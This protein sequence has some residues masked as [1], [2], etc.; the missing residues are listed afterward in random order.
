M[1]SRPQG[2]RAPGAW[3]EAR[4]P[5]SQEKPLQG[6]NPKGPRPRGDRPE[7]AR[8]GWP[9]LVT[10][11]RLSVP[12]VS[13]RFP[14]QVPMSCSQRGRRLGALWLLSLGTLCLSDLIRQDGHLGTVGSLPPRGTL[15]PAPSG[16]LPRSPSCTPTLLFPG[17]RAAAPLLQ[18][19]PTR[20][21]GA[22]P[23]PSRPRRVGPGAAG[24][25][26]LLPSTLGTCCSCCLEPCLVPVRR[27]TIEA[28]SPTAWSSV[29]QGHRDPGLLTRP[30]PPFPVQG[31]V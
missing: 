31:Q 19:G 29:L 8:C 17:T 4:P 22:S 3:G 1:G 11:D 15:R 20:H 14:P 25:G 21:P 9:A 26:P 18:P 6:A 30:L 7:G 27:V 2:P 24:P 28:S 16:K 23:R 5:A 10:T 12:T 13:S